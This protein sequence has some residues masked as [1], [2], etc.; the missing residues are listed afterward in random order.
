MAD[1]FKFKQFEV[2]QSGCAMKIN[3]D[4]VLLG[5]IANKTLPQNIL[6]VGSGTGVIALML[7]QRFPNANLVAVE[8]DELAANTACRNFIK[9]AFNHRL[10]VEHTAIESHQSLIKYD[11][12]VSNPPFFINDFKNADHRKKIARHTNEQFFDDLIQKVNDLLSEDGFFWFI[13]PVKQAQ[14]LTSNAKIFNLFPIRI[15]ELHSD[16]SK[17]AFRQIVC[18]G[19]TKTPI[20]IE[21]FYIY[22][23]EKEYTHAYQE[24]LKDFFLAF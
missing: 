15:I 24:L 4:G 7:A 22:E 23:S 16:N 21:Q 12:I 1:I 6:D 10:S 9:S 3:T 13:L 18:L 19:K 14:L 5:A 11:L 8:I 2:D 20:K 17:P